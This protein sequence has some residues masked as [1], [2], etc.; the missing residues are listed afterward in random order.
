VSP[1]GADFEELFRSNY[2]AVLRYVTRR[3]APDDVQDVVS[4][5][6]IV[7][8]RRRDE[9]RGDPLPWLLGVARRVGANHL[10]G[11]A[12]R[13]A[14]GERLNAQPRETTEAGVDHS[15]AVALA[16]AALPARDREAL[17]LIAW[18]GLEH[19]VAA[20]VM[21]CS[22]TA[23]TVRVHRA[24]R[25]LERALSEDGQSPITINAEARSSS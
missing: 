24:R 5:T 22:T 2:E 19:R 3:V 6:F 1:A 4:E 15:S 17:T 14:L 12:R 9:L 16:L 21:G 10:R 20:S 23:F 11:Q 18:D 13:G 8:W 7:A 25:R